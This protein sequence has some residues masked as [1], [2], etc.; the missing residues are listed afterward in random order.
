MKKLHKIIIGLLTCAIIYTI[1]GL[2]LPYPLNI[3]ILIGAGLFYMSGLITLK[4]IIKGED[5]K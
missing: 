5:K 3:F 4:Q 2:T 1:G